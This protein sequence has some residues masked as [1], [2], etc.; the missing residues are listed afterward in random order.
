MLALTGYIFKCSPYRLQIQLFALTVYIFKCQPLQ[1]TYSRVSPY[2][3]HIHVFVLTG[4]IF[5]YLP[6]QVTYSSVSPCRLHNHV[7]VL[8]GYIFKCYLLPFKKT[9]DSRN[10]V[11]NL[12]IKNLT[13]MWKWYDEVD[14]HGGYQMRAKGYRNVLLSQS[15]QPAAMV[16]GTKMCVN[17]LT[18][19]VL[20]VRVCP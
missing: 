6:L 8:T 11:P 2:R 3:L 13:D 4:Y 15:L 19:T 18:H 20:T 12:L 14:L 16:S 10:G 5:K 7:F 9:G 17:V 1:V